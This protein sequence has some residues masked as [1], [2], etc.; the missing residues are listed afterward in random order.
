MGALVGSIPFTAYMYH[1]N[2]K[3]GGWGIPYLILTGITI[4]LIFSA[5]AIPTILKN[6]WRIPIGDLVKISE[7]RVGWYG[8]AL[9]LSLVLAHAVFH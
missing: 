9:G 4:I 5:V 6:G 7:P 1:L 3:E 8:V 2:D